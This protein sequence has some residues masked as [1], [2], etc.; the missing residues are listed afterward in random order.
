M[1]FATLAR[2]ACPNS[3]PAWRLSRTA[4]CCDFKLSFTFTTHDTSPF[5]HL[6]NQH[7]PSRTLTDLEYTA[8]PSLH[9]TTRV[10]SH[11]PPCLAT[12]ASV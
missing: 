4:A 8:T 7:F 10:S 11:Q 12:I 3:I 5:L 6:S 9:T 1:T 2:D